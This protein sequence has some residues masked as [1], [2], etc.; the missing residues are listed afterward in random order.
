M[1]ASGAYASPGVKNKG[2]VKWEVS[3]HFVC[4]LFKH[5]AVSS[6]AIDVWD[7][8]HNSVIIDKVRINYELDFWYLHSFNSNTTFHK[9]MYFTYIVAGFFFIGREKCTTMYNVPYKHNDLPQI[10][11][12]LYHI[13]LY[14]VHWQAS[15][16]L[17]SL[18][19]TVTRLPMV[20]ATMNP[21]W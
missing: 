9:T 3:V 7:A 18:D 11:D 1:H 4:I 15:I 17:N 19:M 13:K 14:P 21:L 5:S 2:E 16:K 6:C 10:T 12:K 20:T 8:M